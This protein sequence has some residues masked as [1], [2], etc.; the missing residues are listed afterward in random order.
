MFICLPEVCHMRFGHKVL[1]LK[2][3]GKETDKAEQQTTEGVRGLTQEP[4]LAHYHME[5]T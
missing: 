4:V 3:F 5:F 2:T 1:T